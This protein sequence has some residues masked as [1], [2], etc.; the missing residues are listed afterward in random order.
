MQQLTR[1]SEKMLKYIFKAAEPVKVSALKKRFKASTKI[2]INELSD[3]GY[4][5]IA[6]KISIWCEPLEEVKY[7]ITEDGVLNIRK[8]R[9]ERR[10]LIL[11]SVIIPIAVSIVTNLSIILLQWLLS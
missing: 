7:Q 6:S 4:I 11:N 5:Y 3:I 2:S 8:T 10:R 1:D 9:D